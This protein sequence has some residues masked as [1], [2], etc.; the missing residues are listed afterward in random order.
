MNIG[1]KETVQ[2]ANQ[3]KKTDFIG[4]GFFIMDDSFDGLV[5]KVKDKKND[6]EARKGNKTACYDMVLTNYHVVRDVAK[7]LN[8]PNADSTSIKQIFAFEK[9]GMDIV[10]ATG[11]ESAIRKSFCLSSRLLQSISVKYTIV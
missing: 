6:K 10:L 9:S 2:A 5:Q 3:Q 4:S 8:K 7:K 1:I 11:S